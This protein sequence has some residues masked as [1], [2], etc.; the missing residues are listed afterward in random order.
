MVLKIN[1]YKVEMSLEPLNK[2]IKM[3]FLGIVAAVLI[4]VAAIIIKIRLAG[5]KEGRNVRL[6]LN[7]FFCSTCKRFGSISELKKGAPTVCPFCKQKGV[8][9]CVGRPKRSK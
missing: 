5:Q 2:E 3:P 1:W 7:S 9:Q 8:V 4:I 6:P